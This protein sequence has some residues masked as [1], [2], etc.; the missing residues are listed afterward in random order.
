MVTVYGALFGL[1]E[2]TDDQ[3]LAK[4]SSSRFDA[5]RNF[6]SKLWNAVR[7][8]LGRIKAPCGPD[9]V[10]D[11]ASLPAIDRWMLS[12]L[13]RATAD[14]NAALEQFQFSVYAETLYDLIWRD[15]CDWY[16]E[17]IKHTID[18]DPRQQQVL[19]SVLDATLRLLHPVCPFITETA[20]AAV[21]AKGP[22]GLEMLS[23]EGA[24]LLAVASWPV[25][26]DGQ[27]DET[28][29]TDMNTQR[30]LLNAVRSVRSDRALP[31][32]LRPVLLLDPTLHA[33]VAPNA[34]SL[35]VMAKLSRIDVLKGDVPQGA[36]P[37]ACDGGRAC[38]IELGEAANA[39]DDTVQRRIEALQD[40]VG[41]LEGRLGNAGY[42]D[43][44]P[45]KLVQE[46]R[47]QLA[48]AV[49]ELEQLQGAAHG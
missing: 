35:C 12:R 40:R 23:L 43:K 22:S 27:I 30:L 25:P 5:G 46:T 49:A 2:V 48:E 13:A 28:L 10:G 18:E 15:L 14:I 36:A 47:S 24:P 32:T 9:A 37:V 19:L 20:W 38:L 42:V 3:P 1:A 26:A 7:F 34:Q 11:L 45:A 8:A 31:G 4:N 16:L 6:A 17:S 44:A 39:G 41:A 33:A 29:E 21:Q